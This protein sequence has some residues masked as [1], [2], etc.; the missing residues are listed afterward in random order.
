[1]LVINKM[2]EIHPFP[3]ILICLDLWIALV[4]IVGKLKQ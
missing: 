3:L 4:F 1:M 2:A